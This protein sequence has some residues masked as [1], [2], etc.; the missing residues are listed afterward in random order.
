MT[1]LIIDDL[2]GRTLPD[3]R[4]PDRAR[5]CGN[6]LLR[7]VTGDEEGKSG[8]VSTIVEPVAD[9]Y[10]FRGQSPSCSTPGDSVENDVDRTM[11]LIRKGW[12]NRSF[13]GRHWSMVLLDLCFYTGPV[14]PRSEAERGAGMP[15]GRAEDDTPASYFGLTLL[16]EISRQFP[17]LPV[18][19]LSSKNRED[20]SREFSAGGAIA[21]IPRA[22]GT[23][24]DLL[25]DY[26]EQHAI[27]PDPSGVIAGIS[28]RLL[29]ALRQGRRAGAT[30]KNLLIRGESG[31]GKELLARYVHNRGAGANRPFVPLNCGTLNPELA[32]SELFGHVRGSFTDAKTDR[33]GKITL[34]NGGDLFLDEIG[35]LDFGVQSTILRVLEE[36][37]VTPV[38]SNRR[39]SV[40][41]RFMA[42]TD[43]DIEGRASSGLFRESLLF[44]LQEG[45]TIELP[46][47]R[48]RLD[49]L[50]VIVEKLLR[51]SEGAT[52][53][54]TTRIVT[55]EAIEKLA[56][57]SWPGNIRELNNVLGRAVAE[58]PGVDFLA[59]IHIQLP[60][61]NAVA[62]LSR[63]RSP[64]PT[65]ESAHS[66]LG[67]GWQ[68]FLARDID[69]VIRV[70]REFRFDDL[71]ADD[72]KG[73]LQSLEEAF[74]L[75]LVRYVKACVELHSNAPI[76]RGET[77]RVPY[78]Q[79]VKWMTNDPKMKPLEAKRLLRRVF[80]LEVFRNEPEALNE[81]LS[82]DTLRSLYEIVCGAGKDT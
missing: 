25:R 4:N 54:A 58:F 66:P 32:E 41:V 73:K 67:E 8:D 78:A 16:R 75:L 56:S 70:L 77:G 68:Q 18:I 21:F 50:P 76:L 60:S 64:L 61:S 26:I 72:L 46:P 20:V 1:L 43:E 2:Y 30:G 19:I 33:A 81:L 24:P 22:G 6:F 38:G 27:M 44:R 31:T 29:Q 7:D 40:E 34:A 37:I 39:E 55:P 69:G 23:S 42:A 47:L 45:G 11:N 9:A 62:R 15:A 12:T 17:G 74:K 63:A 51:A 5:L 49:D 53:G 79:P 82:D 65:V 36:K 57:H 28:I 52:R 80:K 10:F 14:T 48:E 59:P 35:A 71:D 13:E 3:R